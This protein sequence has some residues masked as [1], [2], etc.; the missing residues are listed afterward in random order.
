MTDSCDFL[1]FPSVSYPSSCLS[2]LYEC[3]YVYKYRCRSSDLHMCK[4]IS[5]SSWIANGRVS[6]HI[7]AYSGS[8]VPLTLDGHGASLAYVL[9]LR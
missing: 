9:P 3:A 4:W 5:P 6:I 8:L 2:S 7:G 1:V